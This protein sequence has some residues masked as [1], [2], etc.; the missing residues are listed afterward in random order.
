MLADALTLSREERH[1][2]AEMLVKH[3]G[4]WSNLG[5]AEARRIA[6]ALE[7]FPIVQAILY[8]RTNR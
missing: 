6:D 5:E 4:S 3:K 1:E 8:M 2:F 7:G